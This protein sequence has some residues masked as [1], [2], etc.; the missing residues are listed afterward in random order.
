MPVIAS[1]PANGDAQAPAPASLAC[2]ARVNREEEG[3][4]SDEVVRQCSIQEELQA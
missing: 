4:Y 1:A 3:T 2:P